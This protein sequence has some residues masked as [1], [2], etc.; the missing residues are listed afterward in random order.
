MKCPMCRVEYTAELVIDQVTR[1][2][3]QKDYTMKRILGKINMVFCAR[4]EQ[5]PKF[6][7]HYVTDVETIKLFSPVI[8]IEDDNGIPMT[9]YKRL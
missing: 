8:D 6:M 1:K 5:G 2:V 7:T 9:L 3:R 4:D